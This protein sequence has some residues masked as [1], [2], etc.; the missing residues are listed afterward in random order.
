MRFFH[1]LLIDAVKREIHDRY[2]Y[3]MPA[4]E[5]RVHTPSSSAGTQFSAGQR[6]QL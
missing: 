3:F 6:L 4:A 2:D 5:T 1:G